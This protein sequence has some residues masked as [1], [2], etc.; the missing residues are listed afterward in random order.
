MKPKIL[1]LNL[2]RMGDLIQTTPL[3]KG[4]REMAP[5]CHITALANVKFA[6]ILKFVEGID[7]TLILDVR[8]F[9]SRDGAETDALAVYNYFDKIT[10][11]LAARGFDMVVNLSHSRLSAVMSMLTGAP[12][13]RGFLSSPRGER[14]VR[15]PWMIYF[16]SF[17]GF[18]RYNKFNLVDMYM[19]SV[20]VAPG[21][22]KRLNLRPDTDAE[23]KILRRL[24]E[25]GVGPEDEV[26]AIQAGASRA[27]RRWSPGSFAS[28][29]D[30]LAR[31]RGAKIILLGAPSEKE[32]GDEVEAEMRETA[33]NLI[34]ETDLD[35]LVGVVRRA[36]LLVTN[37]TGT[38]HI[39][40]AVGTPIVGLFF[41]HARAEETG[42][43]CE[44]AYVVEADIDCAPC[45]HSSQCDHYSCLRYV[46]PED[47]L[48][49]CESALSGDDGH[50]ADPALFRRARV[51]R[52][53]FHDDG[54]IDFVPQGSPQVSKEEFFARLYRAIF[55]EVLSKWESPE[56]IAFP[57]DAVKGAVSEIRKF[58]SLPEGHTLGAWT[59]R[60]VEG[61]EKLENLAAGQARLAMV[62]ETGAESQGAALRDLAAGIAKIDEEISVLA[63]T[64]EETGPLAFAYKRRQESFED[65][66]PVNLA[67]QAKK[68]A[69]WLAASARIFT[70]AA[71]HARSEFSKTTPS[72]SGRSN[73]GIRVSQ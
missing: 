27:D 6:D 46:T 42:P 21:P 53:T 37:D 34:G 13:V 25:L 29:A 59:A 35:D 51:H 11:D 44:G 54:G 5:S 22:M 36:D 9:G 10:A 40:A 12:D 17:L 30:E 70:D 24:G 3:I 4:L 68:A 43:Y 73:D 28:V 32:L 66:A 7:E 69:L 31:K 56:D 19:K 64:Y 8:Q 65:A 23:G 20:G 50:L 71:R 57:A 41:V 38:M 61:G 14:I 26:V 33:I 55:N 18:R 1:I 39:A 72:Y 67:R 16:T 15:D 62:I 63:G 2:T 60:A 45:S 47:V 49:L 52:T 48:A 58:F